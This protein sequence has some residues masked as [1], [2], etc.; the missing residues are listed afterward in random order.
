MSANTASQRLTSPSGASTRKS[1]LTA[2]EK[3]M[4]C[5]ITRVVRRASEVKARVTPPIPGTVIAEAAPSVWSSSSSS[6]CPP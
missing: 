1:A 5:Q 2:I 4:F 3:M 6:C